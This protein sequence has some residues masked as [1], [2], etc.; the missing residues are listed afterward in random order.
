M[1]KIAKKFPLLPIAVEIFEKT[2]KGNKIDVYLWNIPI[3]LR[4]LFL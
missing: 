4:K 1:E 2:K 3:D